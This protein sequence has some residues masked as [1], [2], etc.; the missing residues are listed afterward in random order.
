VN[1][2]ILT[3]DFAALRWVQRNIAAF[4]GDKKK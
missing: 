4:D 2:H 1:I 3:F